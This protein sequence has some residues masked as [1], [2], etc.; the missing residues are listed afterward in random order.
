MRGLTPLYLK[1]LTATVKTVLEWEDRDQRIEGPEVNTYIYCQLCCQ[2]H[3][4]GIKQSFQQVV[5]RNCYENTKKKKE[6]GT[7]PHTIHVN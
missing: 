5:L 7:L 1:L 2:F 6:F 4:M 3:S